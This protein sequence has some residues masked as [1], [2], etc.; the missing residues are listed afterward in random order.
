MT[1]E[2]HSAAW[3]DGFS[4]ALSDAESGAF[5]CIIGTDADA[6]DRRAGYAA[7]SRAAVRRISDREAGQ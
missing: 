4:A 1:E 7:G 2:Q 5:T 6:A 3:W